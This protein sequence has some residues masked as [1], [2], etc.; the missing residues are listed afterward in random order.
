MDIFYMF[1]LIFPGLFFNHDLS[2]VNLISI[3]TDYSQLIPL[4]IYIANVFSD[5]V[6]DLII[7]LQNAYTCTYYHISNQSRKYSHCQITVNVVLS[8]FNLI[9]KLKIQRLM[10]KLPRLIFLPL[11]AKGNRT[12][13]LS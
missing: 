5:I 1:E 12:F 2:N 7:G 11:S 9:N 8:L 6:V 4:G 13:G 3:R 10:N